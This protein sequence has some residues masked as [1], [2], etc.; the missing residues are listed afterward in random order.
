MNGQYNLAF[1]N[2]PKIM[3]FPMILNKN[4]RVPLKNTIVMK[5]D[6]KT[7]EMIKSFVTT[8]IIKL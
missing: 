7:G 1:L 8:R 2:Q 6:S 4:F 3:N 5:I